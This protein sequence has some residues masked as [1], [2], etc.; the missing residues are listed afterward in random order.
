MSGNQHAST[1]R[2]SHLESRPH[3]THAWMASTVPLLL[4]TNPTTESTNAFRLLYRGAL[5]LP[6][7]HILLDGLTFAA[8][9]DSP[10][11]HT[12]LLQNPLALA[13]ESMRGRP[14]LRFIGVVQLDDDNLWLD[15]SG[16]IEMLVSWL[17]FM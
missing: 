4:V 13:L 15:Q 3:E 14:N 11:K 12:Q 6:D 16:G 5:S 8:R 1:T 9:L 2:R 7:S 17:L 10:S